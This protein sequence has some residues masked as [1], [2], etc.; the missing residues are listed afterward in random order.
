MSISVHIHGAHRQYTDGRSS[1]EVEG[2]T[3]G[4]CLRDLVRRCPG[5]EE[6]L[7]DRKGKLLPVVEVFVNHRSTF[8]EELAMQVSDGDEI[9]LTLLLAGG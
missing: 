7:F 9:Q 4:D 8:P 5:I 1:I 2:R 6:R 3:V